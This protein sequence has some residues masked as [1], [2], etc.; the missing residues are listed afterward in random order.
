MVHLLL[1]NQIRNFK[2]T[3]T[4]STDKLLPFDLDQMSLCNKKDHCKESL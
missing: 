1:N 4:F 2:L 3:N